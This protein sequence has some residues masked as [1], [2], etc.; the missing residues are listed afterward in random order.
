MGRFVV[1]PVLPEE[2][3]AGTGGGA[4]PEGRL[5]PVVVEE[6]ALAEL[7]AAA[8]RPFGE[9]KRK[10]PPSVPCVRCVRERAPGSDRGD[11]RS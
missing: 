4:M 8:L 10:A 6:A 1:T 5:P 9:A 7:L 3:P 11:T 2:A